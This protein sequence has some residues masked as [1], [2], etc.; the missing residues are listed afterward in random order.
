LKRKNKQE[1]FIIEATIE[2]D[3]MNEKAKEIR[4]ILG[5]NE[6]SE[7]NIKFRNDKHLYIKN[8]MKI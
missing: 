6:Y 1:D 4:R 2:E 3:V 5:M 7:V 8:K